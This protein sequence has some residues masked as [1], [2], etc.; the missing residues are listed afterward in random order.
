MA[1]LTWVHLMTKLAHYVP[2]VTCNLKELQLP[3]LETGNHLEQ[4][5]TKQ[6]KA[7][8]GYEISFMMPRLCSP[9]FKLLYIYI[10]F[11]AGEL[12]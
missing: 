3:F 9:H 2:T 1:Q 6:Q 11:S 4:H 8:V 12:D 5:N 10:G 7:R